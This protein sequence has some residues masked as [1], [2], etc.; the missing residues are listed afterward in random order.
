LPEMLSYVGTAAEV[1]G[2]QGGAAPGTIVSPGTWQSSCSIQTPWSAYTQ[3][4]LIARYT[5]P[6]VDLLLSGTYQSIPGPQLVANFTAPNALV[7]PALGRNLSGTAPNTTINIVPAG[8]TYGERLKQLDIR[9]GKKVALGSGYGHKISG[10][11]N[12]D[13][14]NVTNTDVAIATN[15]NYATLY[16][17]TQVLPGRFMKLG[18]QVDF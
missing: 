8:T 7:A 18:F 14:Y 16:R 11:I 4:K 13:V 5:I 17:P 2:N 9:V 12:L 1:T 15:A 3:A 10:L 6:K